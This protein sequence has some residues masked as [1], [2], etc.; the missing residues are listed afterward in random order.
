MV[1][2]NFTETIPGSVKAAARKQDRK[3]K[4]DKIC[5]I[6]CSFELVI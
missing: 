4:Q 2:I 1:Q 5:K 6:L 3:R